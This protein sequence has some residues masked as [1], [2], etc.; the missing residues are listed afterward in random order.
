MADLLHIRV[1]KKLKEEM[2]KL[3]DSGLFSNQA[4]LTREA[5]RDLILKYNNE[6]KKK[7]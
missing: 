7:K 5:V 3:I 6:L 2:N 4:E 1:G